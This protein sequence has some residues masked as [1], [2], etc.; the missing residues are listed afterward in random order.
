MN[1][2][3]REKL[4]R[5]YDSIPS[6]N[7]KGLCQDYCGIIPLLP[8]ERE[9]MFAATGRV[10]ECKSNGSC[11]LL[12]EDGKCREYRHRPVICRLWG[13]TE[14]PKMKCPHGCIPDGGFISNEEAASKL[15][16]VEQITM[17]AQKPIWMK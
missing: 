16:A 13:V 6:A 2:L 12:T 11:S 1:R 17:Q 10:P 4:Y 9:N 5:I 14:D 15:D 3:Q 8:A 7:C